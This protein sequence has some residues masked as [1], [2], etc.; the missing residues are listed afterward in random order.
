MVILRCSADSTMISLVITN[1]VEVN[2]F[3]L[4]GLPRS[5]CGLLIIDG[6]AVLRSRQGQVNLA[7]PEN[8]VSVMTSTLPTARIIWEVIFVK[9]FKFVIRETTPLTT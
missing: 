5:C 1:D 3:V 7:V 2:L 9:T 6:D 4:C 8:L